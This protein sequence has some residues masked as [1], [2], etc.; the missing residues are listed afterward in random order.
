M[1]REKKNIKFE[2]EDEEEEHTLIELIR[3]NLKMGIENEMTAE[4]IDKRLGTYLLFYL[5][6]SVLFA[7]G[8]STILSLDFL[9]LVWVYVGLILLAWP[10]LELQFK[11]GL[12]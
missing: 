7:K 12:K 3:K 6:G 5:I 10:Y 4:E 11:R 9:G 8:I 2:R 1:K